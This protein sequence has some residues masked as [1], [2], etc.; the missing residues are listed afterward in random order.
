MKMA[1][2]KKMTALK[3][4]ASPKGMGTTSSRVAS[5]PLKAT[6]KSGAP[7]KAAALKAGAHAALSTVGGVS[8]G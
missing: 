5:T 1:G 2:K 3:A 7:L 6:P 8:V 4:I